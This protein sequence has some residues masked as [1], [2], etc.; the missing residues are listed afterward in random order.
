MHWTWWWPKGYRRESNL[1]DLWYDL[2]RPHWSSANTKY[3]VSCSLPFCLSIDLTHIKTQSG[4]RKIKQSV[5]YSRSHPAEIL[6]GAGQKWDPTRTADSSLQVL[7]STK[8]TS[9][10]LSAAF[11]FYSCHDNSLLRIWMDSRILLSLD[12]LHV[13]GS[14]L[15]HKVHTEQWVAHWQQKRPA[16]NRSWKANRNKK[17]VALFYM[18]DEP[19]PPKKTNNWVFGSMM[20]AGRTAK[21]GKVWRN[22]N[23]YSQWNLPSEHRW[24]RNKSGR[25]CNSTMDH[26]TK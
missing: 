6:E 10:L 5:L 1:F 8:R 19:I 16:K 3:T 14:S 21:N 26:V 13:H 11:F 7:E 22:N 2:H 4:R 24:K 9:Q 17:Y 12:Q 20:F 15:R 25:C 18:D 23:L